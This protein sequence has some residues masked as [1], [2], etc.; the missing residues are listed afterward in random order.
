[1]DKV[2]AYCFKSTPHTIIPPSWSWRSGWIKNWIICNICGHQS[3]I[4]RKEF[5]MKTQVDC[6]TSRKKEEGFIQ[7]DTVYVAEGQVAFLARCKK[8]GRLHSKVMSLG[9]YK[10]ERLAEGV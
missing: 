8:C 7:P 6:P 4:T 9:E 3:T 10:T 5:I 1:M 2:C